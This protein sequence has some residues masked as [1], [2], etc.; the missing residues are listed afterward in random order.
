MALTGAGKANARV[1]KSTPF[2]FAAMALATIA[3]C[4]RSPAGQ[5]AAREAAYRRALA[6]A[7]AEA[8]AHLAYFWQHQSAPSDSEYDFR[9]KAELVRKGDAGSVDEW[10]DAIAKEEGG[11]LSGQLAADP[12]DAPEMHK[13]EVV[14]FQESQVKDWAFF[15]GEKLYGHYTTRVMLPKLPAEQ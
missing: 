1:M 14:E 3:A 7:S 10:L 4:S 2:I 5:E 8:R 12:A 6:A 13:G 15:S 11:K 9:L